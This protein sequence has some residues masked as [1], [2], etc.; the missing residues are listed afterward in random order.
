MFLRGTEVGLTEAYL[1]DD[2]DIAAPLAS[3]A[4]KASCRSAFLRAMGIFTLPA[5]RMDFAAGTSPFTKRCSPTWIRP[6]KPSCLSHEMIGTRKVQQCEV[7]HD[8]IYSQR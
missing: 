2:F 5:P 8:L 3:Q 1:H 7:R 4:G 6:A